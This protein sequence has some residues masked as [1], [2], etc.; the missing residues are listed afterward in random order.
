LEQGGKKVSFKCT[1]FSLPFFFVGGVAVAVAQEESGGWIEDS[2]TGCTVWSVDKPGPAQ[3]VSWTGSCVDGKAGGRGELVWWDEKGLAGRY[4]GEMSA[5]K[6]EGE[7]RLLVRDDESGKFNE[8]VG[9][10]ADSEPEGVGFARTA[11]GEQFVGE[12][13]DGVS[14]AIGT[15]LTPEGW[16]VKGEFE[17]GK[18]VGT[19]IIDYT[20]EDGQR[21]FGQ[22]ENGKRQGYGVLVATDD[23]FYAGQFADGLPDGPGIYKGTGGDRYNGDFANGKPNGFGTSID[24][25]G[26]VLQGRFVDGE[27]VGT[28]LVT[29]SDGTQSVSKANEEG[30]K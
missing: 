9:R 14:H 10:F 17:N 1:I 15:A 12:L 13:I 26:N 25:E 2:V 8:F 19:F 20:T 4:S 18:A 27:P 5:G 21:Y 28:V 7:G 6:L 16:L 23:D 22:A 3:G 29:L 11:N 30:A 24:A